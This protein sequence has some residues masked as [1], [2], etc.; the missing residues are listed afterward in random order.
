MIKE[1]DT[2]TETFR[3]RFPPGQGWTVYTALPRGMGALT[4]RLHTFLRDSRPGWLVSAHIVEDGGISYNYYGGDGLVLPPEKI[5]T[6]MSHE[7]WT[8]ELQ[9]NVDGQPMV[10]KNFLAPAGER[11][12][13][14]MT[15]Y[16]CKSE[17]V[18]HDLFLAL[19]QWHEAKKTRNG[20]I[21]VFDHMGGHSRP[22]PDADWGDL[23]LPPGMADDIRGNI[24]GFFKSGPLYKQLKLAH[25]RGFLVAGPPGNG[26]TMLA[27]VLASDRL[28]SFCWL[29]LTSRLEDDHVAGAFDYAYRHSPGI[30]LIE[31]LDRL[32]GKGGVSMSNILNQLDGMASG[33]GVLVMATTNAPEKLDPALVHR[34]SRFDRVWHVPLPSEEQRLALLRKRSGQFFSAEATAR[35]AE[36]SGGFS[37]AYTQE[38]ITNALVIAAN[39]G[40]EP[41]DSHLYRSLAQIKAQYKKTDARQGLGK[42]EEKSGSLGFVTA[43]Q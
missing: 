23:V 25:K 35:A 22:R 11:S 6:E 8:G 18:M 10:I 14:V 21:T 39:E 24:E 15:L 36:A 19:V 3:R 5:S 32:T 12:F 26:K 33:Q 27:R 30:L 42:G 43:G 37:M 40:E 28:L 29:K 13:G 17:K 41:S 16:A 20:H 9:L 7:C 2:M 31:D 1:L 4:N 38:L 34:P